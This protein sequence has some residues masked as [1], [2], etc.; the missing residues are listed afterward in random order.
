MAS[1]DFGGWKWW[2]G[3]AS[4]TNSYT[5]SGSVIPSVGSDWQL[6]D[7]HI[8]S[9]AFSV[10]VTITVGENEKLKS[11]KFGF[12]LVGSGSQSVYFAISSDG[13]N[14]SLANG[15]GYKSG[16]KEVYVYQGGAYENTVRLNVN[17]GPGTHT[18]YIYCWP[19]SEASTQM[20]LQLYGSPR[21]VEV[22]H[23]S[24]Y[25]HKVYFNAGIGSGNVPSSKTAFS[26]DSVSVGNVIPT[27]PPR[28]ATVSD[29][30]KITTMSNGAVHKIHTAYKDSYDEYI[31]SIWSG[32]GINCAA[33][34]SFT[35]PDSDITL[36][37]QYS[38]NTKSSYRNNKLIDVRNTVGNPEDRYFDSIDIPITLDAATN[39]GSVD[40]AQLI[41][42]K[43]GG[44][45]FK[46]WNLKDNQTT[47]SPDNTEFTTDTTIYAA[48]V[49]ETV[50][51]SV[52]LPQSAKKLP[53]IESVYTITLKM[54]NG[55]QDKQVTA[56]VNKSFKFLGWATTANG[57]NYITEYTPTSTDPVTLYAIF[58]KGSTEDFPAVL[59]VPSKPYN[60]FLGWTLR[61][62][63]STNP[64]E[65][66][67]GSYMPKSDTTLYAMYIP[68]VN[69]VAYIWSD[70]HWWRLLGSD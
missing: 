47:T 9:R 63:G 28:G 59:P 3:S 40:T 69:I 39:G 6:P 16:G 53:I 50:F 5:T 32:S 38:A 27:P 35:M 46:G 66:I 58:D 14:G 23:T 19:E 24:V 55:M 48:W 2:H 12:A 10:K 68:G 62:E 57:T 13:S 49:L 36:T 15:F 26:G 21:C 44:Y 29:S 20:V 31:F 64:D 70:G 30:F 56:S 25:S 7:M 51:K 45:S 43:V 11:V 8:Q 18:R 65:L 4:T 37:A 34:G 42:K 52:T 1:F 54:N 61:P 41:A 60:R 22:D 17:L 33:G 67:K